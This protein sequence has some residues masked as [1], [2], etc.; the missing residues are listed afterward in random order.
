MV[1]G[2]LPFT[3]ASDYEIYQQIKIANFKVP[4]Y[5]TEECRDLICKILQPDI[6]KRLTLGIV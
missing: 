1:T 3:G 2:R 6:S 5:L 4:R